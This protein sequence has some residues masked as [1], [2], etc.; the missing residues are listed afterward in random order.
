MN[1]YIV[2]SVP[3]GEY[4]ADELVLAPNAASAR[5]LIEDNFEPGDVWDCAIEFIGKAHSEMG[6]ESKVLLTQRETCV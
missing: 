2:R 1:L 5:S 6:T 4:G 3:N